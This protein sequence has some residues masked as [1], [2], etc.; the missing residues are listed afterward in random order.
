MTNTIDMLKIRIHKLQQRDPVMNHN[1]IA[2]LKGVSGIQK[3]SKYQAP[4]LQ[5][6][7][8]FVT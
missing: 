4:G 8:Y 7:A 6:G 1:I 3:Q 5:L 2:K